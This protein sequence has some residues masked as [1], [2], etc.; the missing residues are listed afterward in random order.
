M[1]NGV[2]FL[3]EGAIERP[4]AAFGPGST[5]MPILLDDVRCYGSESRLYDCSHSGI[6]R[7]SSHCNH[8]TDAGV[9]CLP[10]TMKEDIAID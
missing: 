10:G 9:T 5:D 7:T 2:S 6:E 1:I 4:N 3:H 8:N